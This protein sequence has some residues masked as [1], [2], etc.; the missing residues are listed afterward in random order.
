LIQKT[1]K[2][3]NKNLIDIFK[4]IVAPPLCVV[5]GK[6]DAGLLCE[7]CLSRIK[8]IENIACDCCGRPLLENKINDTENVRKRCSFCKNGDFNFYSHRSFTMYSGEIKK[9]IK[10]YKYNKI[11]DL[12]EIISTFIMHAYI[13]YYKNEKIDYLETVPGIHMD[14]I[15]RSLSGLIKIP[16]AGNILRIKKIARQQ[17]LD[18]MQRRNNIKGAFKI[19]NCL[20]YNSKNVLVIDD[21]WT[22][23]STMMEIAGVL[24]RA[25]ADKIYL[26]TLARGIQ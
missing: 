11:Y 18:F 13:K 9:V 12:K 23:G 8:E 17:G 19:K 5:C 7:Q 20:L 10:K 15:C 4:D 6:V 14:M 3:V 16:F 22:T 1:Q 21:V 26:L 24:K 2:K 25:G